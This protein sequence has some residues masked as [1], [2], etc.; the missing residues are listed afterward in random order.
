MNQLGAFASELGRLINPPPD[1]GCILQDP[2]L[3]VNVADPLLQELA[4][5]DYNQRRR[6]PPGDLFNQPLDRGLKR[7]KYGLAVNF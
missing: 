6:P 7:V 5:M 1:L 4:A 3:D 2:H